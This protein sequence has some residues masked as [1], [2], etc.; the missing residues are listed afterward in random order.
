MK[1]IIL[2]SLTALLSQYALAENWKFITKDEDG[3]FYLDTDRIVK[4]D[5]TAT[6]WTKFVADVDNEELDFK[7]GDYTISQ[8]IDQCKDHTTY[9][10]VVEDYLKDGQLLSREQQD[11]EEVFVVDEDDIDLAFFKAVCK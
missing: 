1:K 11:G 5:N 6:Y 3:S 4:K 9:S 2:I 10:A 7:K 8:N